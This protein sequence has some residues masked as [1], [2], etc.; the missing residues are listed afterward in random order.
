MRDEDRKKNPELRD[1]HVDIG[2]K[3]GDDARSRVRIGDVAVISGEPVELPNGRVISRSMDNRL[4]CY[5]AYEAARLVAE[6]GGAPGDVAA[7]AVAQEEITFA[8][9]RTTAYSLR[10]DVA[11]VVD[12]TF[13]TDQPGIS[14]QEL[15]KHRFGSGA[16]LTR[17]STLDPKVFELLHEV[18]RRSRSLH[19]ERVGALHGDGR[20][21]V[22]RLAPGRPDR[23]RLD[24]AALHALAGG[25]GA[26]RRRRRLRPPH[27]RVRAAPHG[28]HLLRSLSSPLLLL[29]DIDGTLLQRASVEHAVALKRAV[30]DVHGVALDGIRV[31][32]AG[33][34]D[35]AIARSLLEAAGLASEAIDGRAEDVLA[36]TCAAYEALCPPDL[37]TT[38]SPGIAELL[39]RLAAREDKFVFSL[40][41]GNYERVARL[42]LAAAGIGRFF[43]DGQGAF[44]SDAEHREELPPIAR[45]RAGDWPRERTVVIGDTPRD[46]AC[47]RADGVGVVA[48]AT[49]PFP[50]SALGEADVVVESAG[51]LEGVLEDLAG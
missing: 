19:R 31:E 28:R 14:E 17:G 8:G 6:A 26:A 27:R 49:G 48:V 2:A 46:I 50:A 32:A 41:T 47:A 42:K 39:P 9:A 44:G 13:A 3:D 25:D 37:S 45:A 10:P 4:G 7:V 1:L 22:A 24:P 23:R 16:V 51:E 38:V 34:T 43:A 30:S 12:V 40:V 29:W 36:A 20:R 15:G 11:I 21:R 35:R 33:R 18:G 5:V